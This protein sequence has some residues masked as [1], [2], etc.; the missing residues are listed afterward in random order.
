[1]L[2]YLDNWLSADPNGPHPANGRQPDSPRRAPVARPRSA[3]FPPSASGQQAGRSRQKN[4]RE[5]PE[6]KLRR[7]S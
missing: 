3:G 4:R 1:M 5:W 7:A 6:R 2:F